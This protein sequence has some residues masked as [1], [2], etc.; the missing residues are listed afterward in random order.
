MNKFSIILIALGLFFAGGCGSEPVPTSSAQSGAGISAVP[1]SGP[2]A[3]D[4]TPSSEVK[5]IN[6]PA[7]APK[8][9][10]YI[11]KPANPNDPKYQADPRLGGGGG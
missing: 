7:Q 9:Q 3:P 6:D 1:T 5:V 8:G 2:G 4:V 10:G 11:V